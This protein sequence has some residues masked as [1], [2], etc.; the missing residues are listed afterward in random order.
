MQQ[1]FHYYGTYCAAIISGHTHDESLV[2]A[3]SA[4]FVDCCTR[5]YLG[6]IKAPV[7]A[8]T[9]QSQLELVDA[10]S[11]PLSLQ[12][13][14]RIWASFHF[15]PGDLNAERKKCSKRYL[16]KY[17]LICNTN[18]ELVR[19]TIEL[20]KGKGLEAEGLAMHVLAD[21]WAH[22]YFA[23]T[24]SLVINN[25]DY[26]FYELFPEGDGYREEK[27]KFN[28]NPSSVDDPQTRQYTNSV[29]QTSE[30]SVMNL[31]HGRAGHLPD[32]SYIRYRYMPAWKDYDDLIKDN[33]S[34]YY[35]AFCQMVYAMKYLRGEKP[36]F[37][38]GRYDEQSVSPWKERITG[39]LQ[40]RQIDA[41]ED[42]KAFA[43]ELSGMEVED[44][45]VDQYQA[46]YTGAVK[47]SKEETY[48]G[49]FIS[50]ALAQ[51]SMVTK[52]I[53]SSGNLLAGI[54]VDKEP[55]RGGRR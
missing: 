53:Y 32:Y 37:E 30:N 15:L 48:L 12:N 11:D 19:D 18:G 54:S 34:D 9:T 45:N 2:I 21:T 13:I 25:T 43:C 27:I 8:A 14:T 50:A 31:G 20:A 41:S 33:P 23:G 10:G 29:Y 39:I 52:R 42:W 49:R 44:F 1:D 16:H 28:H 46:E 5:T 35:H 7:N 47:G 55:G 51:K 22:R 6:S 24:P 3:Y 38:T 40:K 4:Q 36:L 17:R 26:F